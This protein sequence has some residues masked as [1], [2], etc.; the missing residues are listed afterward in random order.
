[1]TVRIVLAWLTGA[2]ATLIGVV[3]LI[4]GVAYALT[5]VGGNFGYV[6]GVAAVAYLICLTLRWPIL[7]H[8]LAVLKQVQD[9]GLDIVT[10]EPKKDR[11]E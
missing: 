11:D 10:G 9:E 6:A 7:R 3:A 1:M 4:G 8:N 2:L 5:L